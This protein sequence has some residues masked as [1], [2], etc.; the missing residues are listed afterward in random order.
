[1]TGQAYP[2][3]QPRQSDLEN[4]FVA[5][6][7]HHLGFKS[8]EDFYRFSVEQPEQYW[9]AFIAFYGF[10]WS[11]DYTQFSD[12]SRGPEFPDWFVGGELNWVDNVMRWA[13]H[14][15]VGNLPSIISERE[16]GS[17]EKISYRDLRE[18]VRQLAGG[19]KAWG[20]KRGDRIGLLME[21]GI[22]ANVSFLAISYLGAIVVPLFTGFGVDAIVSRLSSCKARILLATTGF[23]R[24]G[25]FIDAASFVEEALKQLPTVE[26]VFWKASPEGPQLAEGHDNWYDLASHAPLQ[27]AAERM[28]P[29][30]PFMVI[31][32]SGTTGKPKGPVH[33][34]GGFP[35][36]MAH[37][38]AIHI[39]I[40]QGDILC[41][42]ADM[43]WIAGPLVSTSALLN[44]ATLVTYD[45]APDFPNW[46]RMAS[47]IE[48]NK[49]THYGAS[50]TL[51]RG[52]QAHATEAINGDLS[53]IQ[54]MVTA[55][56]SISPEHHHWFH[57]NFG[58]M[59]CP[60]IN[61]TGGTEVS[62]ALLASVVV[63]PIAP[64]CFNTQSPGVEVDVVDANGRSVTG[65]IGELAILKPFVGM[66]KSFWEDDERYLDT[67]WRTNPGL[68]IHGDLALHD[69]DGYFYL[70]GRS[71]DTIKVAGKR[72]GPAEVE[73]IV[74]EL[75]AVS[76]AAAIGVDDPLKGNK[77]LVFVILKP[78]CDEEHDEIKKKIK[79][80]VEQRMGKPFRPSEVYIVEQMPKTR[81]TKV[82]RRLI[83]QIYSNTPLGDLSALDNPAALDE[84]KRVIQKDV[85]NI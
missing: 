35:L 27:T 40:Q 14:P 12:F 41:W 19:L 46:S 48:R 74:V 51:I 26:T 59:D 73:V 32:T 5:R 69:K 13:D 77:L 31:Y 8:Y 20:I 53:S 47:I 21:N 72:L 64:S 52:F 55:G 9:G 70:L 37:D 62:C 83:R 3:W 29:N 65:Q 6:F 2:I 16:S 36:K 30:D 66:C 38:S 82:M 63:K 34:H 18:R 57:Q 75:E 76:E 39:N 7:M 71:D 33:T 4:S 81:S 22:E 78:G 85:S 50:P 11:K 67:Y 24:R 15:V 68:W 79:E 45:G 58:R 44:G 84:I 28:D 10:V 49:V 23:S 25:R 61:I 17:I 56:E 42:P 43:G 80:R 60:I 1:M 54:V